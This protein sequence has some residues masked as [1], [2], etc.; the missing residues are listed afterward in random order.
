ML[1]SL[2]ITIP[3]PGWADAL[4]SKNIHSIKLINAL[5]IKEVFLLILSCA[6]VIRLL[7]SLECSILKIIYTK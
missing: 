3:E 1:P 6:T 2:S 5:T 7:M 4:V